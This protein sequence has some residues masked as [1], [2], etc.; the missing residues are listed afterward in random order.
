[1]IVNKARR[2]FSSAA[3]SSSRRERYAMATE[4]SASSTTGV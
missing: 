4:N 3:F 1:V 2:R